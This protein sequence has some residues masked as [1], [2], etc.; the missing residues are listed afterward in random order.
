MS[1]PK[2]NYVYVDSDDF[3]T[4]S[5]L[6]TDLFFK[7]GDK[8]K[9]NHHLASAETSKKNID[10]VSSS[11][12]YCYSRYNVGDEVK[13]KN[14][15][16]IVSSEE[17]PSSKADE[18][19]NATSEK[20]VHV[21]LKAKKYIEKFHLETKDFPSQKEIKLSDVLENLKSKKGIE[22]ENFKQEIARS[23]ERMNSTEYNSFVSVEFSNEKLLNSLKASS[24]KVNKEVGVDAL[25]L[26]CIY[27]VLKSY[28]KLSSYVDGSELVHLKNYPVGLYVSEKN[29]SG[30]T[31]VLSENE[32]RNLED[33][34]DQVYSIYKSYLSGM[35]LGRSLHSGL[36]VSNLMPMNVVQFIPLLKKSTT[37]TLGIS[38]PNSSGN[39]NVGLS[40]DHRIIDGS[41]AASF[42]NDLKLNIETIKP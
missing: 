5:F 40:F 6:V 34:V 35:P 15:F 24:I 25:F 27:N 14:F 32:L 16:A 41:Y 21:S 8:I 9:K 13:I 19:L 1:A 37:A 7:N 20:M 22:I 36:F 29:K 18:L 3:N 11:E 30:E 31:F 26:H 17:L 28:P 12:G 42:L 33:T 38:S 39:F 23:E 2:L 4:L 10:I